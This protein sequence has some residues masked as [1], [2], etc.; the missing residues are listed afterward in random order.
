MSPFDRDVWLEIFHSMRKNKLRTALTGFSVA[1]GIF[2]LVVLLGVGEGLQNG[3]AKAFNDDASDA[4]FISPSTTALPFKGHNAG[5]RIQLTMADYELVKSNFNPREVAARYWAWGADIS[6]KKEFG[7]FTI[8]GIHTDY[9]GIEGNFVISGRHLN[10]QDINERAKVAVIGRLLAQ[11]LFKG[12]DP[13]G[14]YIK[15]RG[16]PFRVVGIFGDEGGER[17]ERILCMPITTAQR[18]YALGDNIGDLALTPPENLT[19]KE[20]QEYAAEIK[21]ML[22]RKHQFDPNDPRALSI[23]NSREQA[24]MILGV[25]RGIKVFIW[26]IGL[27]TIVAGI[28]GV[29]NIMMIV[30]KDRTREIGVRKAIG[31]TPASIITQI[32]LEAIFITSIFG[33]LGLLGGVLLLESLGPNLQ[34]DYFSNPEINFRVALITLGILVAAGALA[35][36]FPARKAA[37]I[38]PVEALR[39]Q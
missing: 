37:S 13:I 11:D 9:I 12:D 32:I 26:I 28:I 21:N 27:G 34:A 3:T 30:V 36:F 22:A 16:V 20:S 2:M 10:Q 25:M 23:R 39:D 38:N 18:L 17:E 29:A 31:A 33:Y 1:W 5:R 15:V 6:Y 14:A 7:T 4:I 8:R 35:G 19:L 24:E